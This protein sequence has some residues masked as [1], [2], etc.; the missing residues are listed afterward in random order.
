MKYRNS[1][2]TSVIAIVACSV[3]YT[4]LENEIQKNRREIEDNL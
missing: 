4:V 2:I 1:I 3:F